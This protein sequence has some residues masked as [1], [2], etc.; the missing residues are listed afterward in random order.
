MAV[1]SLLNTPKSLNDWQ[2]WSFN[3]AQDHLKIIQDIQATTGNITSIALT[4]GGSGYTSI[5][6]VVLDSNGSGAAFSV[7]IKGGV[8][9]AISVT[10]EGVGY[11]SNLF[12]F[13]GGGGT[14]ATAEIGLNPYVAL[15][16]YQLDPINLQSP[17]D[18]IWHHAQ[19]H[20]DMNGALGLQSIDLSE[21]DFEDENALEA[22]I[23]SNYQE[24]NNVHEALE[25]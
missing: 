11:R 23:F 2:R 13:T 24:H 16:V 7:T 21:I 5:P 8:I 12:E 3:H 9:T 25:I 6:G 17:Q 1:N 18:F 15:Q 22:W 4:N 19:T 14:G 10:S 20:T